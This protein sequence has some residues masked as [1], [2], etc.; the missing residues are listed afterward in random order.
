MKDENKRFYLRMK[1][2]HFA[3]GGDGGGDDPGTPNAIDEPDKKFSQEELEDIIAKRLAREKKKHDEEM[4]RIRDEAERKKLEE[5]EEYKTLYDKA[6]AELESIRNEIRTTQ[7]ESTKTE[8]LVE[9]GYTADQIARVRKYLV[10]EDVESLKVSLEELKADIPPKTSGADPNPANNP[11]QTPPPKDVKE[12]A[13]SLYQQLKA[14]GRFR[15]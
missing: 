12:E 14:S 2:Q 3:D 13:K 7:L 11:R 6:T 9:A 1:L 8:L 4:Q 5:K 15:R 10:G